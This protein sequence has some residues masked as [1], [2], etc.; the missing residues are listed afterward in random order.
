MTSSTSPAS[1]AGATV[2]SRTP[3]M[4]S[5]HSFAGSTTDTVVARLAA[6]S[7][8]RANASAR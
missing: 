2:L 3:A 7:S 8:S 1:T 5:A 4:V 6:L